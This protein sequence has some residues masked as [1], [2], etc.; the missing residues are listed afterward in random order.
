MLLWT[1]I[2]CYYHW[3][4]HILFHFELS[5]LLLAFL[6]DD[7][8][9]CS[10]LGVMGHVL[11]NGDAWLPLLDRTVSVCN[12]KFLPPLPPRFCFAFPFF[13][14]SFLLYFFL[15][16]V[17]FFLLFG[18]GGGRELL[19]SWWVCKCYCSKSIVFDILVYVILCWKSLWI[20]LVSCDRSTVNIYIFFWKGEKELNKY[21]IIYLKRFS[22]MH[23]RVK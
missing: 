2:E 7:V 11:M 21:C 10:Y 18:G 15:C 4:E 8:F 5:P 6:Y 9:L 20:Q 16:F 23:Q 22:G 17:F 3:F 13:F 1:T 12:L 14:F 19:L